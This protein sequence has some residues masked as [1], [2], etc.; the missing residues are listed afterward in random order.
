MLSGNI[1][2]TKNS[3]SE[4]N[5]NPLLMKIKIGFHLLFKLASFVILILSILLMFGLC[6]GQLGV[7]HV[8]ICVIDEQSVP[9]KLARTGKDLVKR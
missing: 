7:S 5:T 4:L 9:M 6:I 1:E 2:P 8:S 3:I